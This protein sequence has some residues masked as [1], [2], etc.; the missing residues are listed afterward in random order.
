[1]SVAVMIA[2]A[3]DATALP[4]MRRTLKSGRLTRG[5]AGAI[6]DEIEGIEAIQRRREMCRG[7][8]A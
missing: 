4:E 6:V 7:L 8:C 2:L 1:M 5:L 3:L